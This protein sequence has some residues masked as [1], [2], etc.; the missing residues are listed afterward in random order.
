M[1]SIQIFWINVVAMSTELSPQLTVASIC[2]A[3][4]RKALAE[5]VGV[6][7]TTISNAVVDGRFPAKWFLAVRDM[8]LEKGIESPEALFTF[9]NAPAAARAS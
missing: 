6:G 4:G 3:I 5:R 1:L 9:A 7:M 2:D 8:C